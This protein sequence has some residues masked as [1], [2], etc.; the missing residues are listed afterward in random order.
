VSTQNISFCFRQKKEKLPEK[1]SFTI[2]ISIT[3][4]HINTGYK[5]SCRN[6]PVALAIKAR[7][8]D[9]SELEFSRISVCWEFIILYKN[10]APYRCRPSPRLKNF[11]ATFDKYLEVKPSKFVLRFK[12]AK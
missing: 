12:A 1:N 10:N 6:C 2:R 11:I 9:P 4:A 3:Q 8:N 7:L 5:Q